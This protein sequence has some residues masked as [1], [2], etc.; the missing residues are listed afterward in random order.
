MIKV[1]FTNADVAKAAQYFEISEETTAEQ[2]FKDRMGD[3]RPSNYLI[4]VNR[5]PAMANQVLKDN[6]RIAVW[7]LRRGSKVF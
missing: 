1:L 7:L 3:V 6:D 2:F 4:R 5:E